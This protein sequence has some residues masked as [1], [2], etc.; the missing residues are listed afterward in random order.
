MSR[1]VQK[2]DFGHGDFGTIILLKWMTQG[3][4]MAQ[5]KPHDALVM[6]DITA[7]NAVRVGI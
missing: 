5:L 2:T 4:G 7:R 3:E 1:I 6:L